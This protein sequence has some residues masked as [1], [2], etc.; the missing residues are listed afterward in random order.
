M[1]RVAIEIARR[2][3]FFIA[4]KLSDN[5]VEG[6]MP[7]AKAGV[8]RML[9]YIARKELDLNKENLLQGLIE[10]RSGAYISG[11]TNTSLEGRDESEKKL[12]AEGAYGRSGFRNQGD[13]TYWALIKKEAK[14]KQEKTLQVKLFEESIYDYGYVKFNKQNDPK[15]GYIDVPRSVINHYGYKSHKPSD[16]LT[17]KLKLFP[18]RSKIVY[19]KDVEEY[20][21]RLRNKSS[22]EKIDNF[23]NFIL[24]KY[25]TPALAICHDDLS[26]LSLDG[27]RF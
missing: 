27:A 10:G 6:V 2:Y 18:S 4:A 12:T 9:E 7:F 1:E 23:N 26:G 19:R 24:E 20:L 25:A 3:E 21:K 16:T 11:Y 17:E 5:P 15:Y 14:H 8:E 22:E 13:G